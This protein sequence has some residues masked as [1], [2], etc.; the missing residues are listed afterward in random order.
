ME[1]I[2]AIIKELAKPVTTAQWYQKGLP[3]VLKVWF[4]IL[5]FGFVFVS[6]TVTQLSWIGILFVV[7]YIRAHGFKKFADDAKSLPNKIKEKISK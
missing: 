6:H 1:K 2:I 7:G 4:W 5:V 3:I